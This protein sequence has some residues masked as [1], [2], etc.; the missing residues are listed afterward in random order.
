MFG[1]LLKHDIKNSF[2]DYFLLYT[3]MIVFAVVAPFLI[4]AE[5]EWLDAITAIMVVFLFVGANVMMFV[6]TVT[7]I[8]RRMFS[9]AAY[10][11]YTL[12]VKMSQTLLSKIIVAILW[13]F[14][15]VILSIVTMF[16][17]VF[18][19]ETI[20]LDEVWEVIRMVDF[21]WIL[22]TEFI[23][24]FFVEMINVILILILS[25]TIVNSSFFKR[26]SNFFV[27]LVF[28]LIS[29]GLG[30]LDSAF[31]SLMNLDIGIVITDAIY[32]TNQSYLM[33]LAYTI[34]TVVVGVG[35]F[36]VTNYLLNNKLEI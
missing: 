36:I 6:N 12:P 24:L 17:F 29:F 9:D 4:R 19:V 20:P 10:L 7:F 8:K 1:K 23:V 35:L 18:G 32:A 11:N 22:I 27:L 16:I 21:N 30:M 15:T 26:K 13:I 25:M 5:I 33:I 2:K 28:L 3:L 34:Y 14:V 31:T